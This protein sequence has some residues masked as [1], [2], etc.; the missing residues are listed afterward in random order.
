[1]CPPVTQIFHAWLNEVQ[2]HRRRVVQLHR[3]FLSRLMS[4]R[5]R[6]FSG[7]LQQTRRSRKIRKNVASLAFRNSFGLLRLTFTAWF[8]VLKE[9]H[10]HMARRAQVGNG[11]AYGCLCRGLRLSCTLSCYIYCTVAARMGCAVIA[12]CTFTL[13]SSVRLGI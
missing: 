2:T 5:E 9:K 7:W 10:E 12:R 4:Q 1:M 3:Y 8:D 11:D 6:C 13:A